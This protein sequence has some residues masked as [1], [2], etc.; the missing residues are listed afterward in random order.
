MKKT[1]LV[2]RLSLSGA[3]IFL[4]LVC[5]QSVIT[6]IKFE[7]AREFRSQAVIKKLSYIRT[8]EEEYFLVTGRY[9][10]D[11][12][13][14]L[15]FLKNTPKREILKEG[16]LTEKQ[17]EAGLTEHKAARIIR[18]AKEKA[19]KELQTDN[20]SILY[21]YIYAN[22]KD[23]IENG[24]VGFRRDTIIENMI[25]FVYKGDF[26]ETTI[27]DIIIIPYTNGKQ[28][29]EAE[30]NND[31]TTSNGSKIPLL[32]VRAHFNTFLGDLDK[33][34]RFNLI[35]KEIKLDHYPGLKIGSLDAPNKNAG[36]W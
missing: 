29:F 7:Q 21:D 19:Q 4:V 20:D 1:R 23:V 14:L 16:S 25:E 22:D 26:D 33:Q 32:E 5:V 34:E 6:P 2:L 28:R 31:Y 9:T 15:Y 10:A 27:D 36:N 18:E 17:L 13:S 12:D 3:I 24:L 8:A 11:L 30:V 35:D